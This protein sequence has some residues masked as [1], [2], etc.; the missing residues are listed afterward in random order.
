MFLQP[1]P[2]RSVNLFPKTQNNIFFR[3]TNP[4][5]G[6]VISCWCV[7]A[8]PDY[9]MQFQTL[10]AYSSLLPHWNAMLFLSA[11]PLLKPRVADDSLT[12]AELELVKQA[13]E[14]KRSSAGKAQLDTSAHCTGTVYA[15]ILFAEKQV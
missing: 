8:F 10:T 6:S 11:L 5:V 13:P 12:Y 1:Y 2:C 9:W 4:K 15:Q 14:A 7:H 3:Q